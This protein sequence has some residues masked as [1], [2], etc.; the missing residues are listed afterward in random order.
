MWRGFWLEVAYLTVSAPWP[1]ALYCS[2]WDHAPS[3]CEN[4][5]EAVP[6]TPHSCLPNLCPTHCSHTSTILPEPRSY[7]YIP[8]R[9]FIL[10]CYALYGFFR[11]I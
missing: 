1:S 11:S 6:S 7:V 10:L 4:A 5:A 3:R 2:P 8:Q 9:Q